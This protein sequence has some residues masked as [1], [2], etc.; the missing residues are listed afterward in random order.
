V[1]LIT[2][3]PGPYIATLAWTGVTRDSYS[4]TINGDPQLGQWQLIIFTDDTQT[5]ASGVISLVT[6]N[7]VW[8]LD[9]GYPLQ[10]SIT[11]QNFDPCLTYV[12]RISVTGM[13]RSGDV[14]GNG[15]IIGDD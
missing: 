4:I 8:I 6:D 11:I 1:V 7:G 9:S 15:L 2:N 13:Q 14:L 3:D 10:G 5:D 12:D